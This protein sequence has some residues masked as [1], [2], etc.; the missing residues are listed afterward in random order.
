MTFLNVILLGGIAAVGIPLILHFFNRSRPRVV[1]WGAMHLLDAAFQA[2]S[3]RINLEQ[4]LLLLLRC[5]IPV[6]L[7]MCMARPVL[8]RMQQLLGSAKSSLVIV[9]DDSYSMA[10]S[11]TGRTTFDAAREAAGALVDQA[12]RGSESAVVLTGGEP[13]TL[14]DRPTFDNVRIN[15][16]LAKLKPELGRSA[17]GKSLLRG[18]AILKDMT[19][20]VR[21]LIVISDFQRG[22]LAGLRESEWTQLKSALEGLPVQPRVTFLSVGEET[23]DNVAVESLDY[24]KLVHGVGQAFQVRANVRNFGEKP[25][26]ALRV[27]FRVNGEERSVTEIQLGPNE[28]RQVL[29]SHVFDRPGSQVIEVFADADAL[30]QDNTRLAAV[31]VW[32]RLPVV[33]VNGEPSPLPLKGETDYLQLAL[34]PFE[35]GAGLTNLVR[36]RIIATHELDAASLRGQ[37][38]LVLANV[39]QLADFQLRAVED[40]V[41]AGGGLLLFPGNRVNTDWHN[42]VLARE[43]GLAPLRYLRLE[44]ETGGQTNLTRIAGQHFAHPVLELFNDPR[45]GKLSEADIRIWYL[46]AFGEGEPGRRAEILSLLET[47]SPFL[48]AQ[49]FGE[50]RVIQSVIPCDADWGNLPMRPFYLPLMQRLVTYL[51]SPT[52]PGRNLETGQKIR[53]NYAPGAVP[54]KLTLQAPRGQIHEL[55]PVEQGGRP[56]VEFGDTLVPGLYTLREDGRVTHFTAQ[57]DAAESDLA[58]LRRAELEQAAERLGAKVLTGAAEFQE[59]DRDRRF[60]REIWKPLLWFVLAL[61]FGELLYQQWLGRRRTA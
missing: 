22:D 61:L 47:G 7:A 46:A 8:T 29:F 51:A 1:R 24:S 14:L 23:R 10:A 37:R 42:R 6:A 3:R 38:V 19:Q 55:S 58:L 16:E 4:L 53:L 27:F 33:L 5:L 50:G 49:Q 59:L 13:R 12:G 57:N 60:G 48:A 35:S 28:Q 41:R 17:L 20:P 21:D 31:P 18:A 25:W 39:V 9:L 11:A 32:D 44:G 56:V 36:A 15:R 2:N 54:A 45:N 34:R 52:G 40:F 30:K 26:P 43:D